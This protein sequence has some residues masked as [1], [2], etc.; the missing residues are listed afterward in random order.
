M[1][2]IIVCPK[3]GNKDP[4]MLEDSE[5]QVREADRT[6]T[7]NELVCFVCSH[8]WGKREITS[9]PKKVAHGK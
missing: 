4:S 5:T 3:C 9:L 2:D 6:I 7:F 8:V 1:T